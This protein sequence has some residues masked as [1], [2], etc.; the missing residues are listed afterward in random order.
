M[1]REMNENVNWFPATETMS[2]CSWFPLGNLRGTKKDGW[3]KGTRTRMNESTSG[4]DENCVTA[5]GYDKWLN[6]QWQEKRESK[7]SW[8]MRK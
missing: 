2:F 3:K 5:C 4:K 6:E 1:L 8:E 7:W